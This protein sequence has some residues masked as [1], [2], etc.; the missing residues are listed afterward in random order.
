MNTQYLL[1]GS[2][3]EV[4]HLDVQRDAFVYFFESG[5]PI[6]WPK[7]EVVQRLEFVEV[8]RWR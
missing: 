6:K 5:E 2:V 7:G 1:V 8:Q 4:V 3:A